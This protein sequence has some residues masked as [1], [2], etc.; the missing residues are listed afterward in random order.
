M[1]DL[2]AAFSELE[3]AR[4]SPKSVRR[5][6]SRFVDL[7]QRLTSAMRKVFSSERNAAWDANSFPGWTPVTEF[8]KWLR[9]HDQHQLPLRISVHERHFYE[10]PH[11]PGE[12]I[13]FEGTWVLDNQLDDVLPNGIT[14]R[15]ADPVSGEPMEPISPARVEYQYLLQWPDE[16]ARLMLQAIG[17]T[18]VHL[19]SES[20]LNTLR[21]YHA[22]F[23]GCLT[24]NER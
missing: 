20:A 17:T 22:Y 9:N 1:A 12:L 14:F 8:L 18:D 4:G 10:L 6:F 5:A 15:P 23:S 21:A 7:T 16:E 19:L 3:I 13:P 24:S 11:M 2:E